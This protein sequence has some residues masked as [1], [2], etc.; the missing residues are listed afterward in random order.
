MKRKSLIASSVLIIA[1]LPLCAAGVEVA[2]SPQQVQSMGVVT[3][4]AVHD[5]RSPLQ[6]LSARV[7]VPNTQMNVV[8]TPLPGLVET[9]VVSSSQSVKKGQLLARIQSPGL[10]EAQRLYVQAVNQA[11][12]SQAALIRDEALWREGIIAESR[13]LAAKG[14]H[15]EVTAL[16]AE[17]TQ[18]LRL[19]GMSDAGQCVT[20][21]LPCGLKLPSTTPPV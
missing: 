21:P 9:L 19:A 7:V 2:V 10:A 15:A 6:G 1:T 3:A 13:Y 16:L 8:S 14:N 4:R 20:F 12:L 11:T 5:D 18:A 17:R